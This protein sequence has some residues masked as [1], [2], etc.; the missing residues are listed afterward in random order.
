MSIPLVPCD[1]IRNTEGIVMKKLLFI[2]LVILFPAISWSIEIDKKDRVPNQAPGYCAWASLETL[3]RHHSILP[4]IDLVEKRKKDSDV[5]VLNRDA[6]GREYYVKHEK[7]VGNDFVLPSKLKE[8]NVSFK[9]TNTGSSDR[10]L[11]SYADSKGVVV[12]VKT[13][14]RGPGAHIIVLT[15]YD[16]ESIMFYDCNQPDV[17]WKGSREWFDYWWTG[18]SI[19]VDKNE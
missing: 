7:H 14:A 6:N 13:G 19:L 9:M 5:L 12:G 1:Y 11:L 18:L 2:L 3:G 10:S 17:I 15:Q 8:L 4:L 16:E